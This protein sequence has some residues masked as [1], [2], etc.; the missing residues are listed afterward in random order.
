MKR[1]LVVDDEEHICELYR[2][3]LEDEGYEV[4]VA[5][6]GSEALEIIEQ[7][8]PDLV[9]LDI[10]MP[11]INGIEILE[12]IVGRDKGIPVI[13]NTAYSHYRDDYTTWGAEAYVV[14][15]SDTSKLKSE[16][17]RILGE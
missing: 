6:S 4:G 10:Q 16:V 15:S 8:P 13:L 7:A 11:G 1:I 5:Q 2:S 14:K 3:E 12:K 17:K 9:I